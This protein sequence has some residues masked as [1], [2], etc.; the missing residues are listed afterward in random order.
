VQVFHEW[1]Y[2]LGEHDRDQHDQ[3]D[4]DDAGEEENQRDD[5]EDDQRGGDERPYRDDVD[6]VA[7]R[8][9]LGIRRNAVGSTPGSGF[10]R[11]RGRTLV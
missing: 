1:P 11:L 2:S 8:R 10:S 3:D 5:T 4:A 9:S 6:A 7:A